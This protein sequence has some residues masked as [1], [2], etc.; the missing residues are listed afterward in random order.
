MRSRKRT[1]KK[2]MKMKAVMRICDT[3]MV[4]MYPYLSWNHEA[5]KIPLFH[6]R[7]K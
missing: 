5:A 1:H 2:T 7:E 3:C 6:E 4:L